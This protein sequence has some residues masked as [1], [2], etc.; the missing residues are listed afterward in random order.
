MDKIR[1]A[2]VHDWLTGQR[3]GEKVLEV[4]AEVFPQAPIFT[5]FHFPGSQVP[6]LER[7]EIRTSFLER[8]PFVR[9]R[10]RS[11]LPLF[12][13]AAEL[14]DLQDYEL[15]VSTSHCVAKG[16]IPNPDALHISYIHSPVRYAWNQY[17]AYFGPGKL[18]PLSRLVV[19][20]II[21]A[22]RVWDV[23]SAARVDRF[24][25]N[26]A[27]VARRIAKYYRREADV[28]HPP[29]DTDFYTPG[30]SDARGDYF[31]I[32]SALV[33]YK[34]ID[35]AIAAADLSG[36]RLK[37]VGT[38][39]DLKGLRRRSG[40]SVE[41]L[42]AL[43]GEDLRRLY[44]EARALL[45]PGEEDFGIAAVE[46]QACGTPVIAYGRGGAL[47][48]VVDGTTGLLFSE[49]NVASLLGVLDKFRSF[50]CNRETL[51]AQALRFSRTVFREK[52]EAYL[53]ARWTEFKGAR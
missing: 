22:L 1:T 46:A 41:F 11:Y 6:A 7:R 50:P 39:P 16:V 10:Y 29:V 45:M 15:V 49:L 21:H 2:L 38:G 24:V 8:M 33:P 27:A 52:L 35:L 36:F 4:L 53:R 43:G 20:P 9:S 3:G 44:R 47:E 28:L 48:T 25:A 31:L 42:G 51:R 26:S 17:S 13:L 14:F 12:P 32:V 40:R 23:A 30:P 37:V 5:L 18:G 34:R 19:P